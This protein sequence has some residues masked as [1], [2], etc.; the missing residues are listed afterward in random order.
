MKKKTNI[1]KDLKVKY[2]AELKELTKDFQVKQAKTYREYEI[3]S[4]LPDS[5]HAEER[6]EITVCIHSGDTYNHV[7]VHN[8]NYRTGPDTALAD[9]GQLVS[10]LL[11][12]GWSIVPTCRAA[13]G[14]YRATILPYDCDTAPDF[15][16]DEE[17]KDIAEVL[18][19]W[20]EDCILVGSYANRNKLNMYL[21]SPEGEIIEFSFSTS[22]GVITTA[23]RS[24]DGFLRGTSQV[25][26]KDSFYTL[27][28]IDMT[29]RLANSHSR[30][31]QSIDSSIDVEIV[32]EPNDKFNFTPELFVHFIKQLQGKLET[33]I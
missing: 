31:F 19:F 27:Y 8:Y 4:Q 2:A 12:V 14:N 26:I 15:R 5:W 33:N 3:L 20:I 25:I 32:W 6:L 23:K 7:S 11:S 13:Y 17:L 16:Y 30:K 9:I 29:T 1:K 18:P 10:E 28:D 22:L 21:K 24:G